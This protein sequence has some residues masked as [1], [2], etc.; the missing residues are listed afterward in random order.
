[1]VHLFPTLIDHR[2]IHTYLKKIKVLDETFIAQDT[3][4]TADADKVKIWIDTANG[5]VWKYF[6][7]STNAWVIIP[8]PSGSGTSFTVGAKFKSNALAK[9]GGLAVGAW[10]EADVGHESAPAGVAIRVL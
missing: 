2:E 1:M 6:N 10:Y 4:P 8:M 9:A 3:A 5:N 7:E